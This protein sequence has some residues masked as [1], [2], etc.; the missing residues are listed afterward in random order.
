[1][2]ILTCVK[3]VPDT[4][5]TYLCRMPCLLTV[6]VLTTVPRLP[7]LKRRMEIRKKEMPVLD[8][9]SFPI[10]TRR[11]GAEGSPTRVR[12]TYVQ[13]VCKQTVK[14]ADDG[15]EETARIFLNFLRRH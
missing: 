13:Q 11:T 14:V 7:G 5:Q 8:A 6:H 2:R 4:T 3:Q 12:K 9:A 10:D 15:S 1:M